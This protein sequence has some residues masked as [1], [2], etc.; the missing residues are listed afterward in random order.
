[1]NCSVA[2]ILPKPKTICVNGVVISREVIA[3]EVQN[4]P[5]E[6]PILAWQAAARALVVRELLLQELARLGIVADG[7]QRFRGPHGDCGRGRD[8]P[9]HRAR[10]HDAGAG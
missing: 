3:R 6:R 9:T 5:A 8:A 1:M 2:D 10:S 4:H 7:A